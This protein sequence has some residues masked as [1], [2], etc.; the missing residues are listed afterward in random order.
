MRRADRYRGKKPRG[1]LSPL[2]VATVAIL[3]LICILY[4]TMTVS[5]EITGEEPGEQIYQALFVTKDWE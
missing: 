4:M 2:G 5:A 1:G 3:T